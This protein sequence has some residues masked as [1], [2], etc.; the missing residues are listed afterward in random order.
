MWSRVLPGYMNSLSVCAQGN[1][2]PTGSTRGEYPVATSRMN[3]GNGDARRTPGRRARLLARG[4]LLGL[5]AAIA[6]SAPPHAAL[7]TA[8]APE[9][10][11]PLWT[12]MEDGIGAYFPAPPKR[13]NADTATQ[14]GHAF[15][16]SREYDGCIV[17]FTITV[18]PPSGT[19]PM[20]PPGLSWMEFFRQT[21]IVFAESLGVSRS[22][23]RTE[24]SRFGKNQPS[25]KYA[26]PLTLKEIPLQTSGFWLARGRTVI[27]VA[28]MFAG[29]L[30]PE[31]KADI[32][33]F[34]TTF[35]LLG[36]SR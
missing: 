10:V 34:K 23:V 32:E 8:P 3:P 16:A 24:E 35:T 7:W 6:M 28:T 31:A 2:V 13:A 33:R 19:E 5:V 17:M 30:S 12:S 4:I 29:T 27:R 18:M 9:K 11:P 25:L 15:Q 36:F 22:V 20:P 26:F 21:N 14:S 1:A